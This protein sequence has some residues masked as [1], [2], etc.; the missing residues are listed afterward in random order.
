MGTGIL[1]IDRPWGHRHQPA[2][3]QVR[4]STERF[5]K[6]SRFFRPASELCR[7]PGDIHLNEDLDAGSACSLRRG[8][9]SL[10]QHCNQFR[11]VNGVNDAEELDRV[12]RLV[13]L[14]VADEVP[15]HC[16]SVRSSE[17]ARPGTPGRAGGVRS[18]LVCPEPRA[19][20]L[21]PSSEF[22]LLG[23][24][25]LNAV[26]TQ[27]GQAEGD[28]LPD[29]LDGNALRHGDQRHGGGVAADAC[30]RPADPFT[31]ALNPLP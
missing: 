21:Q 8:A 2:K 31:D 13:A 6:P 3:R 27:I 15:F 18:G 24:G 14:E 20:S 25:F 30:A 9:C 19:S 11:R 4:T 17:F 5:G 12:P 10:L 16:K 29:T 23:A 26:F 7:L 22:L 1:R 28:R